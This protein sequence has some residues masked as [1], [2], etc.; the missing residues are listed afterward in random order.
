[1]VML[2]VGG[3]ILVRS[4]MMMHAKES[5]GPVFLLVA[6]YLLIQGLDVALSEDAYDKDDQRRKQEKSLYRERFGIFAPLA[7]HL[8]ALFLAVAGIL[9]VVFPISTALHRVMGILVVAAIGYEI[10]LALWL[11]RELGQDASDRQMDFTAMK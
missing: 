10:W 4:I 8:S 11:R 3:A 7:P 9:A 5:G 6:L 2:F 1:M